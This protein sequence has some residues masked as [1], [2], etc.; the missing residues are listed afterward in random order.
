MGLQVCKCTCTAV[1]EELL[2]QC[3]LPAPAPAD[4]RRLAPVLLLGGGAR[5]RPPCSM[6]V[7]FSTSAASGR[8]AKKRFRCV[9]RPCNGRSQQDRM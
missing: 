8:D 6:S 3:W 9:K 7:E 1:A 4:R 2:L 5:K